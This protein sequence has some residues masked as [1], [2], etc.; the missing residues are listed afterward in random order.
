MEEDALY[1]ILVYYFSS[2][3][4]GSNQCEFLPA[5]SA[6]AVGADGM[7]VPGVAADGIDGLAVGA[8]TDPIGRR[9]RL[10]VLGHGQTEHSTKTE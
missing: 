3:L 10:G 1:D 4:S 8:S 5:T 6:R 9:A 7:P 2:N